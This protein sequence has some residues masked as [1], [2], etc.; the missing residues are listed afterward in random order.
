MK[1]SKLLLLTIFALCLIVSE[2]HS[3][4]RPRPH[5]RPPHHHHH[6]I[7]SES[8]SDEHPRPHFPP[9]FR[10]PHHHHEEESGSDSEE[11]P[12]PHFPPHFR[13]PHHHHHHEEEESESDE[14]HYHPQLRQINVPVLKTETKN[15]REI[16]V[17][18]KRDM[19]DKKIF[20]EEL[21]KKKNFPKAKPAEELLEKVKKISRR[22]DIEEVAYTIY[23]DSECRYYYDDNIRR[24]G[25]SMP[26]FGTF[27]KISFDE[28]NE[29]NMTIYTYNT[30]GCNSNPTYV[31]S[32]TKNECKKDPLTGN[33]IKWEW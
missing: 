11:H 30:P 28:E 29:S 21:K 27:E 13:P 15:F 14:H 12:H 2:A 23:R 3:M 4:R 17:S 31:R 5:P 8:E 33:Y 26:T 22:D 9:H 6:E 18:E 32:F 20:I 16:K 24:V 25:C 7:E 1:F 10:P 19:M